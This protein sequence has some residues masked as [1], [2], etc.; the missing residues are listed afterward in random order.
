M[1]INYISIE[2]FGAKLRNE[3][4]A[5]YLK[6]K[7]VG[8]PRED[9]AHEVQDAEPISK[10][11]WLECL[12]TALIIAKEIPGLPLPVP[13]ADPLGFCWLTYE[14]GARRVAVEMRAPR[15]V[16]TI[17]KDGFDSVHEHT[18]AKELGEALKQTFNRA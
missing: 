11:A 12:A 9:G 14:R 17:T 8:W 2:E 10:E 6:T 4:G 18:T 13:G 3:C 15:F 1:S 16:W 5:M 7:H